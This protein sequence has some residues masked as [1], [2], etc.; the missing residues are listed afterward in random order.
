M[1]NNESGEYFMKSIVKKSI[2]LVSLIA[3]FTYILAPD[4]ANN[5]QTTLDVEVKKINVNK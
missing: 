3:I 5:Y 2:I 4:N 1:Y